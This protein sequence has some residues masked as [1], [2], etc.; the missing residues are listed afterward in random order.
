[1]TATESVSWM[2]NLLDWVSTRITPTMTRGELSL[3]LPLLAALLVSSLL[4]VRYVYRWR[5]LL[6]RNQGRPGAFGLNLV[7][8]A[9]TRR[10]SY[11]SARLALWFATAVVLAA[12]W[13]YRSVLFVVT[14]L[15]YAWTELANAVLE[16]LYQYRMEDYLE[17]QTEE[18]SE[19]VLAT[20]GALRASESVAGEQRDRMETALAEN[21]QAIEEIKETTASTQRTGEEVHALTNSA[22]GAQLRISATL[23]RRLAALTNDPGDVEAAAAAEETLQ[24][25]MKG[26][27]EADSRP[28]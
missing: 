27:G 3:L 18:V 4:L 26:Q 7:A 11:R 25:H 6:Q 15:V 13:R 24:E 16:W 5:W 22:F 14:V 10:E 2:E 19:K 21:K 8:R 20:A 23:A 9:N 12:D 17:R 28:S 1:M